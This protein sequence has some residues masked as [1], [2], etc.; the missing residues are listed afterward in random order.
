MKLLV[1][2]MQ[3]L[4]WNTGFG[5]NM[6][7]SVTMKANKNLERSRAGGW[8][9]IVPVDRSL[10]INND[11]IIEGLHEHGLDIAECKK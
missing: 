6:P 7:I 4:K 8:Y 1:L 3:T 5:D 10:K 2:Q 9:G 11:R